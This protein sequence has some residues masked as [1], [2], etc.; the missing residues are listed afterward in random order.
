MMIHVKRL[1]GLA[2]ILTLLLAAQQVAAE[3]AVAPAKSQAEAPHA[4]PAPQAAAPKASVSETA[5]VRQHSLSIGG[6]PFAYV[7]TAGTLTLHDGDDRPSASIFYVAYTAPS[8]PAR[9]RPITFLFNGGPGAASFWLQMGSV[10]PKRLALPNAAS[11][12]LA[13]YPL[14]DNPDTLL[15]RSDLVFIDAPGTG[16][17]RVLPGGAANAFFSVDADLEA[18]GQAIQRYLDINQRFDS[19]KFLLGESYGATR[20]AALASVLERKGVALN[21]VILLSS[22]LNVGDYR[23]GIDQGFINFVPNYAAIAW[24]HK[25]GS[26]TATDLPTLMGA[27]RAFASGPYAA[28]LR[29]GDRVSTEEA[30]AVATQLGRYIGLAPAEILRLH[31]RV[32]ASYFRLALLRDQGRALGGLDARYTAEVSDM[33]AARPAFDPAFAAISSAYQ[34]AFAAYLRSDLG[35]HD[36]ENYRFDVPGLDYRWNWGH[37]GPDGERQLTPDTALDL[38]AAMQSNPRLKVLSLNGW[39]DLSTPF[40]ATEYDLAHMLLPPGLRGNLQFKYYPAGHMVYLNPDALHAMRQ[41]LDGFYGEA[42]RP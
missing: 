12:P 37:L 7:T 31:L 16:F 33:D 41:D 40:F 4:A 17:S 24:Y 11:A 2:T 30:S 36:G 15:D 28:A 10:G 38:S 26:E 19:P 22:I 6:R 5:V 35:Y 14:A 18:F 1:S 9:Q 39:Y 34:S 8:Q 23:P 3:P 25:R 27:V 21:G 42:M 29:K 13:P 20:A 32:P